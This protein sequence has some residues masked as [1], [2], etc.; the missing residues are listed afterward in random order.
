[1]LLLFLFIYYI[2]VASCYPCDIEYTFSL[3]SFCNNKSSLTLVRSAYFLFSL[4]LDAFLLFD[5]SQKNVFYPNLLFIS[6]FPSPSVHTVLCL[7]G[8]LSHNA[9]CS[10]GHS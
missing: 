5:V 2:F 7:P 9:K 1:M 3:S 6:V 4:F 8:L 10:E